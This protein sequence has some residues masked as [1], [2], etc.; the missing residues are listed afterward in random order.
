MIDEPD[1]VLDD[2]T[3]YLRSFTLF[4]RQVRPRYAIP[5][6]VAAGAFAGQSVVLFGWELEPG[7][8]AYLAVASAGTAGYTVGSIVGWW[9]GQWHVG[10]GRRRSVGGRRASDRR[11]WGG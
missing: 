2:D 8:P 9:I 6:A 1:A 4:M 11:A 7:F 3:H 5:F 10:F